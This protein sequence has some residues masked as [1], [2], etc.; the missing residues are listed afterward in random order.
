MVFLNNKVN[1]CRDLQEELAGR[2]GE[3]G[4]WPGFKSLEGPL[5]KLL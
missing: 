5:I 1:I 2:L 4:I 3:G